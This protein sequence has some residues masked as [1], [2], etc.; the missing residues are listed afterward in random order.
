MR[1]S[2]YGLV[3]P[4]GWLVS[5]TDLLTGAVLGNFTTK[6]TYSASVPAFGVQLLKL[7]VI[8]DRKHRRG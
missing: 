7:T 1:P 2:K 4:D 8:Q 3:V 5:L 6:V